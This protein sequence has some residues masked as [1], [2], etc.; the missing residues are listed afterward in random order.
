MYLEGTL[1]PSISLIEKMGGIL[2]LLL[3]SERVLTPISRH[4][5][6]LTTYWGSRHNIPLTPTPHD[7]RRFGRFGS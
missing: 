4:N 6:P 7:L 3:N 1:Y 2:C 5:F